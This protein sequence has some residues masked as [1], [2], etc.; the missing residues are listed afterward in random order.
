[1]QLPCTTAACNIS[2]NVILCSSSVAVWEYMTAVLIKLTFEDVVFKMSYS[3]NT[4]PTY[5]DYL[6]TK[7]DSNLNIFH[8]AT[9]KC[10]KTGQVT[11][12]KIAY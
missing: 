10:V 11:H 8:M 2:L 7:D 3:V 5:L 12:N 1:M 9:S 6:K 4:L